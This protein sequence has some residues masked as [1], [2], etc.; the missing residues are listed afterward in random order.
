MRWVSNKRTHRIAS[1]YLW[2][3]ALRK[4]TTTI[5]VFLLYS[6]FPLGSF[7]VE[8]SSHMTH[9]LDYHPISTYTIMRR[10]IQRW[11]T[12]STNLTYIK[13]LNEI[14]QKNMTSFSITKQDKYRKNY[15]LYRVPS[16]LF[17]LMSLFV[18]SS[19]L[20]ALET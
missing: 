18:S 19:L 11:K 7:I 6:F 9:A 3:S 17:R 10:M 13:Q 15:R 12:N 4:V 5:R 1:I 16:I 8:T 20:D 14:S 2:F